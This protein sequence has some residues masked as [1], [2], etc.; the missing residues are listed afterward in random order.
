MVLLVGSAWPLADTYP[1]CWITDTCWCRLQLR[2]M[3]V[4]RPP[5][6]WHYHVG[7]DAWTRSHMV[8]RGLAVMWECWCPRH[9][10]VQVHLQ[11]ESPVALHD[12]G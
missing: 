9:E 8:S 6:M 10:H 3:T 7:H 12:D 11:A 4:G 5:F 2:H 1:R